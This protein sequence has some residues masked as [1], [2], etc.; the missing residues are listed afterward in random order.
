MKPN[1]SSSEAIDG[2]IPTSATE[3]VPQKRTQHGWK[4]RRW[5]AI[6]T[7]RERRTNVLQNKRIQRTWR[8]ISERW[9]QKQANEPQLLLTGA[10]VLE[11]EKVGVL[12]E[13]KSQRVTQKHRQDHS[14]HAQQLQFLQKRSLQDARNDQENSSQFGHSPENVIWK[15][16]ECRKEW[17]LIR[18]RYSQSHQFFDRNQKETRKHEWGK[19]KASIRIWSMPNSLW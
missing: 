1:S 2:K 13:E 14:L 16:N 4:I 6:A 11:T 19:Q 15:R 10:G 18:Q 9:I 8:K 12:W 5:K 3:R 17:F 7:V